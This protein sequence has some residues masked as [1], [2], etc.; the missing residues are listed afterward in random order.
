MKKFFILL[1]LGGIIAL[2]SYSAGH[3]LG[4]ESRIVWRINN[5]LHFL[6]GLYAF[7]LISSIFD[8]TKNYHNTVSTFVM[9]AVIF[10]FGALFLGVLWEWFE[11][12]FIYWEKVS[13]LK[14]QGAAIY[15]DTMGD[16]ALDLFGALS[17]G[18]Y[19]TVIKN[20]KNK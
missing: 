2:S 8:I 12:F 20:G 7:F 17:A 16:L 6:G 1:F 5:T 14:N 13:M 4:V 19:Y 3:Y 9:K 10:I 15:I 18:F 11:L